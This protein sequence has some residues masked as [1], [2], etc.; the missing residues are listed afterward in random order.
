MSAVVRLT[1]WL[2]P[3]VCQ[4]LYF[5]TEGFESTGKSNSYDDR[6]FALAAILSSVLIYNLPGTLYILRNQG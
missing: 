5:D 6:I 1:T 2:I 4:V 3:A